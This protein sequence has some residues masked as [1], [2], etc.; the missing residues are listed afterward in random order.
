[1]RSVKR[2]YPLPG[3]FSHENDNEWRCS[4]RMSVSVNDTDIVPFQLWSTWT[5]KVLSATLR[6]CCICV[7]LMKKFCSIAVLFRNFHIS[8]IGTSGPVG[9]FWG[10]SFLEYNGHTEFIPS[11]SPPILPCQIFHMVSIFQS[12]ATHFF[13]PHSS[14]TL[15]LHNLHILFEDTVSSHNW[16]MLSI[17]FAISITLIRICAGGLKYAFNEFTSV[18]LF[19]TL[20]R[21]YQSLL[22]AQHVCIKWEGYTRK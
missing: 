7:G 20:E 17:F 6:S 22:S 5:H 11:S 21:K 13:H 4:L 16:N 18:Q 8:E 14:S 10:L 1:M 19:S 12:R 2:K 9:I 15:Y 3:C